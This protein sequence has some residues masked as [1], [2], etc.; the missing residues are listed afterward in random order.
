MT[1]EDSPESN[2]NIRMNKLGIIGGLGPMATVSF[3]KRIIDM[4]DASC[5]QEHIHMVVEHCP[6]IPDRTAY[7]LDHSK[8]NPAP[9]IIEACRIL[10]GAGVDEIA[11]PCVTAH[12]FRDEIAKNTSIPVL[13]GVLLSADYLKSKGVSRVGIMATDGT[14]KS[15]IFN[16]SLSEHGISAVVPS[17]KAQKYV[18]DLIYNDVK[19]GKPIEQDKFGA[20]AVELR[21]EGAEVI[22]LGCTELSVIADEWLPDGRFLD[23]LSVLSRAC[24]MDFGKLK[25]A[26]RE[27]L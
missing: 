6:T 2:R 25:G 1:T 16:R 27:L 3:M 19:G 10:E 4:T 26:Y 14:I 9:A 17:A 24:V 5:D 22:I 15:G 8:D 12:F 11:I 20:V 21:E 13:D 7:I 23:V 18:M